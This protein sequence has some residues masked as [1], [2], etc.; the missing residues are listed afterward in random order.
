MSI[1]S[2]FQSGN[3]IINT[4]TAA[5]LAVGQNIAGMNDPNYH[6]INTALIAKNNGVTARFTRA[7]NQYTE[8]S[9][10]TEATSQHRW[11]MQN[12]LLQQVQSIFNESGER[13]GI[14]KTLTQFFTSWSGLST[15]PSN[16]GSKVDVIETA[17]TLSQLL[18]NAHS[19]IAKGQQDSINKIQAD[20][21]KV[22]SILDEIASLNRIISDGQ[23]KDF[24]LLD[25]RDALTRELSQYI[26]VNIVNNNY[27]TFTLTTKSGFTLVNGSSAYSLELKNNVVMNDLK[28]G[29]PYTG[30]VHFNGSS[31]YEYKVEMISGGTIGG[32]PAPTFRVSTDGGKT[33]ITNPDTGTEAFETTSNPNNPVKV[34]DLE[35]W[36]D[37]GDVIPG[38][39]FTVIPKLAVFWKSTTSSLVNITPQMF[40]DGTE[41]PSRITGGSL[42]ALF[43]FKDTNAGTY[44]NQL[45]TFTKELIWQ[46]NSLYS[47]S[48]GSTITS[49]SGNQS[50]KDTTAPLGSTQAGLP[51]G[52]KLQAGDLTIYE[53]DATGSPILPAHT[54]TFD[55][56]TDSLE[57]V[58]DAITAL[59][60]SIT[61]TIA[62]G[63][64][65]INTTGGNS[66]AFSKDETGLLAGLGINTFFTGSDASSIGV[67]PEL[68]RNPSSVNTGKVL[69]DGSINIGDNSIALSIAGFQN[70]A[71]DIVD[72]FGNKTNATLF[73]YYTAIAT[74]VGSDVNGSA[75]QSDYHKT[76][77]GFWYAKGQAEYGVSQDE[78]LTFSMQMQ[79]LYVAGTKL[80]DTARRMLDSLLTIV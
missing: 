60:P 15:N 3:S 1:T 26:D 58:R 46:I 39:S 80:I 74:K 57:D 51:F 62:D 16:V 72:A 79:D 54:V 23:A 11:T 55:P 21:T 73:E 49:I 33:W 28:G 41:N 47:Q 36:F 45:N 56:N 35:L 76:Q 78:E 43:S 77:A 24:S 38:D 69:A 27:D 8:R 7:Y 29:S 19:T 18:Q 34:G 48:A 17:K 67:N 22:N 52:D 2:L 12:E 20:V 59:S 14:G 4:A 6:K 44:K 25:K 32:A 9:F 40:A 61:A 71:F 5:Q 66:I 63:K 31:N 30:T 70:T 13:Q 53:Y 10:I 75:F 42:G 65:Q 68:V 64:L 37:A 50:V